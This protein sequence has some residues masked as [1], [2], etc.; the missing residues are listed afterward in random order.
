MV[1]MEGVFRMIWVHRLVFAGV[2]I[3][4]LVL[5]IACGED[6]T[7]TP[8]STST[9]TLPP[10][11]TLVSPTS[12]PTAVSTQ[13]PTA[14]P[15]LVPAPTPSPAP[16]QTPR[17]TTTPT[18]SPFPFSITDSNGNTVT[19]DGPPERIVAF[20]SEAVEILFAI[21]EGHRIVGTHSFVDY[22]PEVADIPRVG[23][24]FE[25][26]FE[27]I[28][29]L[30][31]DLV[32]VFF[33]RFAPQLEDLGLKV[34]YI[35]SLNSDLPE[36][37]ENFRNWGRITGKVDAAEAE[38]AKIQARVAALEAKLVGVEKRPRVYHHTF[39]FWTPGG[40]T[41]MGRIYDLLKA[42]LVSKEIAGFPQDRFDQISP[43]QVVVRDPEVIVT[44]A[45]AVE[46][47]TGNPALAGVSAVKNGRV[48][49]PQR[50]SLFVAATQLMDAIEELAELLHPD[51]FG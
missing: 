50:G 46:Q 19:F 31:P 44:D 18:P 48:V 21:G 22:P 1:G 47:I 25:M 24:A 28:V 33:D 16:T 51:K 13:A 27:A 36:M 17:P 5:G 43:E 9:P 30:E 26:N 34:L 15:T 41:L 35:K 39:D 49:V 4:A 37:F 8:A 11:G 14:T 38:V 40:D 23:N 45:F 32:Y 12:T 6:S 29:A 7:A 20:D 3:M 10:A 2:F 42:D